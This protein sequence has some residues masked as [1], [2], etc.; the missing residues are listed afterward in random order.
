M[1]KAAKK[2]IGGF[3]EV[4]QLQAR[5]QGM[6]FIES[7]IAQQ[8][9]SAALAKVITGAFGIQG[10]SKE[11]K[12]LA[13][14]TLKK[15][16]N[17]DPDVESGFG[18]GF[19]LG[20]RGGTSSKRVLR[21]IE[22][23]KKL[24]VGM[25][26]SMTAITKK[27][28][29]IG[30]Q[31][32]QIL[33]SLQG[34]VREQVGQI[35]GAAPVAS[36]G[37]DLPYGT[38]K[39]EGGII[40]TKENLKEVVRE[41]VVEKPVTAEE[42][43]DETPSDQ[44]SERSSD[45]TEQTAPTAIPKAAAE[46]SSSIFEKG[47]DIVRKKYPILSAIMPKTGG[48]SGATPSTT[49][50]LSEVKGDVGSLQPALEGIAEKKPVSSQIEP[51]ELQ[52]LLKDALKDAFEEIK[53]ENPELFKSE[54][55]GGGGLLGSIAGSLLG[56]G[57]GSAAGKT[58]GKTAAKI[59]GKAVG[60]A[61]LKSALKKIPIVGAI[62]GLGFAASRAMAGDWTGA[63]MEAGSGLA[64]TVPG[65]G[66]T[67]SVGI[68][69]ALAARDAG[70]MG[71]SV[72][73]KPEPELSTAVPT[74]SGA[75]IIEMNRRIQ[76]GEVSVR[77]T[78]NGTPIVQRIVNNNMMP[79]KEKKDNIEVGN[80]ESTFNRLLAQDFDHPSTYSNFNMG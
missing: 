31:N 19:G 9:N 62:A 59:G 43:K 32:N 6:G 21:K 75:E 47:M 55:G 45:N 46:K 25:A 76:S 71:G 4:Q 58:A 61:V 50:P 30:E 39:S 54:D 3:A 18:T 15:K 64:G 63:A 33:Q 65:I 40:T 26:E 51:D 66:T 67:A 69:A 27:T 37:D 5:S 68:D 16:Y 42:S 79:K 57:V 56:R 34:R 53:S 8:L 2:I 24:I 60:K 44:P 72:P 12:K 28:D 17:V 70:V 23:L 11:D 10:V 38:E 35:M 73:P 48:E 22:E 77:S 52:T 41:V 80:K 74:S 7:R 13:R 49:T 78:P 20:S 1:I 29:A 14:Q 36:G